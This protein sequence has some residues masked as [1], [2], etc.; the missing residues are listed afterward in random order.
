MQI[1]FFCPLGKKVYLVMQFSGAGNQE[2][3]LGSS[4]CQEHVLA[5]LQITF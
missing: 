4:F 1:A 5:E 3:Q 2:I